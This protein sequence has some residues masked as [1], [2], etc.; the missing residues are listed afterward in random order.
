MKLIKGYSY[1]VTDWRGQA[2]YAAKYLGKVK[3]VN[4]Q[5]PPPQMFLLEIEGRKG[6]PYKLAGCVLECHVN[7][8]GEVLPYLHATHYGNN[9]EDFRKCGVAKY[10][11]PKWELEP[12][13]AV[14]G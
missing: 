3:D 11:P 9:L 5:S 14:Y 12:E 4:N 8:D 6:M 1:P 10:V 2:I 13:V 7:P